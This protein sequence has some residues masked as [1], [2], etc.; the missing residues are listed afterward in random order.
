MCVMVIW[1]EAEQFKYI[2]RRFYIS[3]VTRSL[4]DNINHTALIHAK[5]PFMHLMINETKPTK[6]KDLFRIEAR[7]SVTDAA[8]QTSR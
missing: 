6:T 8:T 3:P 7:C 1:F 5:T 4:K 2:V